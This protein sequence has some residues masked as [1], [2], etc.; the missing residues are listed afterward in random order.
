MAAAGRGTPLRGGDASCALG[1][2]DL[3]PDGLLAQVL[4]AAT[5]PL[6]V[7]YADRFLKQ[8][9]SLH[10]PA[11]EDTV[12][13][14]NWEPI[15]QSLTA[16]PKVLAMMSDKLEW[17][18][19]LGNAV[20]EDQA[21][22]MDT[23][24]DLRKRA[25][26]AG[27]LKS[28]SEQ[29]VVHEKDSIIIEPSQK[30]VVYVPYY[31][32]TVVYGAYAA[33]YYH[34]YDRY[35]GA[36]SVS[37]SYSGSY[38]ISRNHWGWARADWNSRRL[39]MATGDNRFLSQAGRA[40][41]RPAAH[42]STMLRID[43]ASTIPIPQCRHLRAVLGARPATSRAD[44]RSTPGRRAQRRPSPI[45]ACRGAR[46]WRA[47]DHRASETSAADHPGCRGH[48]PGRLGRPGRIDESANQFDR[49]VHGGANVKAALGAS[50][51]CEPAGPSAASA[52][53]YVPAARRPRRP[54]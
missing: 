32:S 30:G 45:H 51:A 20:L 15:V 50:A 24:Q 47:G 29:S 17:T 42:G 19:R 48:R 31:D 54:R 14:K 34:Y 4:M 39:T 12:A 40:Q 11:L 53:R 38:S 1:A 22:V 35:Y 13:E 36:T 5:Y 28:T 18:E 6:E 33:A 41:L 10:G 25:E 43:A 52:R 8:N 16:Y 3:Y 21:R 7:V 26:A 44:C 2:H 49:L 37:V 23:V 46:R 9:R 27:N